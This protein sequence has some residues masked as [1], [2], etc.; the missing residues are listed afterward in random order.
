MHIALNG[1]DHYTVDAHGKLLLFGEYLALFG[2]GACGMPLPVYMNAQFIRSS[3]SR[4]L[5]I[6]S[7][8]AI[9]SEFYTHLDAVYREY[10]IAPLAGSITLHSDIPLSAGFGSSA[11]FCVCIAKII[12]R[13]NPQLLHA[14]D[15]DSEEATLHLI[16]SVAHSLEHFFHY[17]ASGIDTALALYTYPLIFIT[18]S[19]KQRA[20][21]SRFRIIPYKKLYSS[22]PLESL[23]I[24]HTPRIS[25]TAQGENIKL[26][27]QRIQSSLDAQ[28]K[29]IA[30]WKTY[31]N[32]IMDILMEDALGQ[33]TEVSNEFLQITGEHARRI[34]R[35]LSHLHI[36]DTLTDSILT[37]LFSQGIPGGKM[38][39]AGLGGAFYVVTT[40]HH[41]KQR[42]LVH[43]EKYLRT[44]NIKCVIVPSH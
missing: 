25:A 23:I 22:I 6:V 27:A 26:V 8:V 15:A 14:A 44:E 2:H 42:L 34:H 37:F 39:G 7:R 36:T 5:K 30:L 16:W 28:N 24:A 3:A 18:D 41:Q 38:S 31:H 20:T 1:E 9:P 40:D 12:V 35:E 17:T 43:L 11:A 4:S 33:R 29:H 32:E 13:E 19:N 10:G 21:P